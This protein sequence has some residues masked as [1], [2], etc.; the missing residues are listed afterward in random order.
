VWRGLMLAWALWLAWS[1]IAWLRWGWSAYGSGGLW[2][3]GVPRRK[4]A[5]GAMPAGAPADPPD[6]PDGTAAPVTGSSG[7]A[8]SAQSTA[9]QA[10]EAPPKNA[11]PAP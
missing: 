6:T 7:S 4:Q 5:A 11:P 9:S 3:K 1:L 8:G 10:E 2:R